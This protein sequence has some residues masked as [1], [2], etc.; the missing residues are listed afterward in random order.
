MNIFDRLRRKLVKQ[1]C[2]FGIEEAEARQ[3]AL[4]ILEHVTGLTCER[5]MVSDL[6]ES[7]PAWLE[8]LEDIL[9]KRAQR[10]PI[11][12]ALG[13]ASFMG[14]DLTITKGVLVPRS[15]TEELVEVVCDRLAETSGSAYI[16]DIG[17][18]AGPIA[19]A[20]LSRLSNCRVFACDV[21]AKA[22]ELTLVNA[23]RH[24]V[25]DRLEL[26]LGDWREVLPH[27]FDVIVS[28]P[29]YISLRQ[30]SLLAKEILEHEPY[31]ALF[32]GEGDGLSFYRGFASL[33]TGHF[34]NANGWLAC[35]IGDHMARQIQIIFEDHGWREVAIHRDIHDL[36]RVL[37]AVAPKAN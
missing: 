4:L 32:D 24:Q 16:A 6:T 37:T 33:L 28:N 36:A 20:L 35:E 11:Q 22:A 21:N 7:E 12:Y 5:Q 19:I 31:E 18:G 17:V 3:E 27:G 1:L 25:S 8:Q 2:G 23:K 29:P 26:A 13:R 9:A 30:K 10:C 34:K 14:L 15:D